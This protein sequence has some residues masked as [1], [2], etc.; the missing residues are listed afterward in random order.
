VLRADRIALA[1]EV[2]TSVADSLS[3]L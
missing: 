1:H 3:F 2:V